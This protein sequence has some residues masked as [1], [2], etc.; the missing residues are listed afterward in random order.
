MRH[1]AV[2]V[3]LVAAASSLLL[4]CPDNSAPT[5]PAAAHSAA[6]VEPPLS[7]EGRHIVARQEIAGTNYQIEAVGF[8]CLP[9]EPC[10]AE[11]RL[12]ALGNTHVNEEYPHKFVPAV[13]SAVRVAPPPALVRKTP[14]EGVLSLR[15]APG[16]LS[17]AGGVEGE[18]RFSVCSDAL[19]QIEKAAVKLEALRPD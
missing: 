16:A 7:T 6:S 4:G 12:S 11:L 1:F 18:F 8:A 9:E 19:C 14:T 10:P 15:L 5:P 3:L 2:T 17:A 13:A